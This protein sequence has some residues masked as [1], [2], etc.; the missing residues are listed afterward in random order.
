MSRRICIVTGSRADYGL[1]RPVMRALDSAADFE[2]QVIA[3]GSHLSPEFGMTVREIEADGF[4]VDERVEMLLSSDSPVGVSTSMGI[5]TIKLAGA[6]ERL[7]PDLVVVLGDRY[8]ILS[9]VQAALVATLP[10]AHLS[11]GDIT[12]GAIDDALRHAITKMSHLHFPTNADAARR[13]IQMGESPHRVLAVGNPGLDDLIHFTPMPRAELEAALGMEFRAH[14]LLVTYHPVTLADEPPAE[15][16]GE[17]LAA[18]D[19]LGNDVG[20]IFTLPNADTHGRVLIEMLQRFV[21]ERTNAVAHGSL[22]QERY[23]SCLKMVD[24]VVGNSSSGLSEVPAVGVP[25]VNVGERQ[26]GRL[27]AASARD[28]PADRTAIGEAIRAALAAGR[29]EASSPY[30]DGGATERILHTLRSIDDLRDLVHK[31]FHST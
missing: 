25:A 28:C 17:L 11:G 27:Q 2:L 6:Y 20:L 31:R 24:A 29:V 16:F 13:V 23:W 22:G 3:T 19:Q 9:A 15:A 8:E 18:L 12:E 14:N 4:R 26:R 7:Q 10:V 30:G 21:R 5:A 1:L